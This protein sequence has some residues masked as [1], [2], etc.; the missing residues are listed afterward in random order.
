MAGQQIKYS[1]LSNY[2][3]ALCYTR[4]H[5]AK[6]VKRLYTSFKPSHYDITMNIHDDKRH[7]SGGVVVS[8][9][10]T[11]RPSKRLTF[12]QKGLKIQ[13]AEITCTS[14]KGEKIEIPITRVVKQDSFDELRLHSEQTLYPGEY[15]VRIEFSGVITKNMDGIYPCFFEIDGVSKELVATQFESHHARE[16]FPCI[17]EPEAKATFKLNIEHATSEVAIANTPVENQE[18][19]ES[20]TTTTFALTPIMST[21]LVAFVVGELSYKESLSKNGIAIRTYAVANQIDHADFALEVAVK[22]MDFY[23]DYYDIPFPLSKCDFVALPDFASGAMEN[24]GLITFREQTMLCDIYTSLG[25]KQY[26]ALVVAHELTHQWFGNLVTMRWWTD[27]WLN[28]GFAS[29]MEYLAVD[30]LYPEWNLWTQ[31]SVDEQQ[32]ALKADALEFTH[33][34]EVPV[35]HPDEIRTIFDIISYQK[36]ASVIHMLN[37]YLGAEQFQAGLRHY[38]KKFAYKNADTTDLWSALEEVSGKPVMDFMHT[39][40]GKSGY[41]LLSVAIEKNNLICSQ[42]RFVT[43]PSSKARD[44]N[45]LWPIPLLSSELPEAIV[46]KRRTSI[47]LEKSQIPLL[48]NQGLTGFYRVD[49]TEEMQKIQIEAILK[50]TLSDLDRMGLLSDGFEVTKAGFQSTT[51][52]L[53]LLEHY[54]NETELPAWEIIASSLST[55]RHTLAPN[56]TDDSLRDAMKPFVDNLTKN[57]I[58]RLGWV[59]HDNEKHLDTLL[60]PLIISLSAS[61]DNKDVLKKLAEMYV[62]KIHQNEE[63]DPDLRATVYVTAARTGGQKI[64]DELLKSYIATQSSDEKLSITAAMTSFQQPEIHAQ[65]LALLQT[66]TIRTQDLSY[67]IAYSFMNRHSRTQTWLW[68][69]SN[70]V[71]LKEVIGTDLGFARIPV[72]VARN[73]TD[74]KFLEEYV[75]FFTSK[76]EPV[77]K[78]SFDQGYEIMQTNIAWHERDSAAVVEWF[79]SRQK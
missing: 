79:K 75:N 57:E 25:T 41:P 15:A 61:A 24:W 35:H 12:H 63:I 69:K 66:S 76:I 17:D 58:K 11:G 65:V 50:G 62:V 14:K 13:H 46:Q 71:W 32:S 52:Y 16:A 3:Q 2:Q 20:R 55:I 26:I 7:F 19:T 72:Y 6:I 47:S 45:T 74:A 70:W 77:I 56:D 64:Y 4:W 22:A 36:G 67:W 60:R 5:M 31:F 27:L 10:K 53:E 23:E 42:R 18:V 40:T 51:D 1:K 37:D 38:L 54:S 44:D 78:R 49:Y 9:Q 73:F 43:N 28:E 29:W 30:T 48:I 8:G 34:I 59:K 33:P 39:W 68:L 21:Y